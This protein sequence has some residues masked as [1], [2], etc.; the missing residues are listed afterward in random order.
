MSAATPAVTFTFR[1]PDCFNQILTV[2][3]MSK[4]VGLV[5]LLCGHIPVAGDANPF[6]ESG[7]WGFNVS[8]VI[9]VIETPRL[10][11]AELF[12]FWVVHYHIPTTL[13]ASPAF[14]LDSFAHFGGVG[15]NYE[16]LCCATLAKR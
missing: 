16:C 3:P 4:F 2:T 13:M 5:L 7:P 6:G 1:L 11:I 14:G 9:V 8:L 12:V 15:F 10:W